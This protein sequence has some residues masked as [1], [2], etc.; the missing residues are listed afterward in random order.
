M[1]TDYT[2]KK[3]P[4]QVSTYKQFN[5]PRYGRDFFGYGKYHH[6]IVSYEIANPFLC[7]DPEFWFHHSVNITNEIETEESAMPQLVD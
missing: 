6:S 4:A 1:Y 7:F 2:T 3:S 5:F